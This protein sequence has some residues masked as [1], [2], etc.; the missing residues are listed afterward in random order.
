MEHLPGFSKNKLSDYNM[1]ARLRLLHTL[2]DLLSY[3][4]LLIIFFSLTWSLPNQQQDIIYSSLISNSE[5]LSL[6]LYRSCVS[7]IR[8][9]LKHVMYSDFLYQNQDKVKITLIKLIMTFCIFL[10][11]CCV[12]TD[13]D[14]CVHAHIAQKKI[15]VIRPVGSSLVVP[16]IQDPC[17]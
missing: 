3:L 5:V 10:S 15:L 9:S 2:F 4:F 8:L 14:I 12:Y 11:S 1:Q 6:S 7:L 16:I 17:H 13:I